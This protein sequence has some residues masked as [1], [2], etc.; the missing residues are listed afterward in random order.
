MSGPGVTLL[1]N[2]QPFPKLDSPLVDPETGHI[3]LAWQRLLI[4][5]WQM[6]GSGHVAAPNGAVVSQTSQGAGAPL[7]VIST[8]TGEILG[9]LALANQPGDPAVPLTVGT[10]PFTFLATGDGY[11]VASSGMVEVSRNSGTTWQQVGLCGGAVP[12]AKDDLVRVTWVV[13]DP[14]V[15]LYPSGAAG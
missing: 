5:L 11:L 9:T 10:S 3:Q 13:E 6:S 15:V 14:S 12:L 4:S 2:Y 8:S 1:Y 7:T